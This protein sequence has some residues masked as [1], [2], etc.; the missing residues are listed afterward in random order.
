M[1]VEWDIWGKAE[2][3]NNDYKCISYKVEFGY[4]AIIL[5]TWKQ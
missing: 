5:G 2:Y 1:L 3:G 4:Q